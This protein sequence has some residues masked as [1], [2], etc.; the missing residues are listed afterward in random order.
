LEFLAS[1]KLHFSVMCKLRIVAIAARTMVGQ[2]TKTC[3]SDKEYMIEA[4][5][6]GRDFINNQILYYELQRRSR[7]LTGRR[8]FSYEKYRQLRLNDQDLIYYQT[9][10]NWEKYSSNPMTLQYRS[11]YHMNYHSNQECEYNI[12]IQC[13]DSDGG[14]G[15]QY[16]LGHI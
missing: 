16:R 2:S 1:F 6:R 14:R 15:S 7:H 8:H 9:L 12:I 3:S 4:R 13:I 5:F 11:Y 10:R